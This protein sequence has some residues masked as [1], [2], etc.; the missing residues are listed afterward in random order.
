MIRYFKSAAGPV[1]KHSL[2]IIYNIF[3]NGTEILSEDKKYDI[4][5]TQTGYIYFKILDSYN[6]RYIYVPSVQYTDRIETIRYD[7]LTQKFKTIINNMFILF[8]PYKYNYVRET[9]ALTIW[10]PK[11]SKFMFASIGKRIDVNIIGL[12][13]I[14]IDIDPETGPETPNNFI[15]LSAF[16]RPISGIVRRSSKYIDTKFVFL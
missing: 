12:G 9:G 15:I 3:Q 4:S 10:M 6:R 2:E 5:V 1:H 8:G 14:N 11:G 13:T 7:V 16:C